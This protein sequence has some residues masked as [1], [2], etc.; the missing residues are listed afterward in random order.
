MNPHLTFHHFGLAVDPQTQ[1]RKNLYYR[2]LS[3]QKV[4]E[5]PR[6]AQALFE[7]GMVETSLEKALSRFEQ[8]CE[9][10]P[11]YA[12]AWI[13]AG[14]MNHKLGHFQAALEALTRGGKLAPGNPLIAESLGDVYY[15]L[16]DF[17]KAEKEYRRTRK[18]GPVRAGLESK[19]GLS[20]IRNGHV[21][22]GMQRL[23]K[24]VAREPG[25]GEL[26]DRLITAYV[27]LKRPMDAA[28]AAEAKLAQT[29]ASDR[30][31]LRAASIHAQLENMSRAAELL[32]SGLSRFPRSENW[33]PQPRK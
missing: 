16:G 30:D 17:Q 12:E 27:W 28:A 25:A 18:L 14:L 22:E 10:K 31:Y 9:L 2:D 7:L 11:D 3:I 5:M 4:Q 26:H 19:L 24:A 33:P 13:F 21:E 32:K 20:Q 23:H 1:N 6:S 8:A 15:D 29:D